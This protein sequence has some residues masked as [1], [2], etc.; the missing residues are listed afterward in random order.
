MCVSLETMLLTI[1]ILADSIIKLSYIWKQRSNNIPLFR[2]Q[3]CA[4]H[5]QT[6]INQVTRQLWYILRKKI[7]WPL[8]ISGSSGKNSDT[9][10]GF[11]KYKKSL[12]LF[13]IWFSFYNF[14]HFICIKSQHTKYF[15]YL[16]YTKHK[17]WLYNT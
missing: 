13:L 2:Y 14:C 1:K 5:N 7:Q 17:M 6:L 12:H 3:Y 16:L 10:W 8:S 4:I 11:K 15:P 9:V